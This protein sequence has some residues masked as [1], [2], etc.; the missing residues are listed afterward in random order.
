MKK[1][2]LPFIVSLAMAASMLPASFVMAE[3]TEEPAVEPVIVYTA[4]DGDTYNIYESTIM[5]FMDEN[6][7]SSLPDVFM[8]SGIPDEDLADCYYRFEA[9]DGYG[10]SLRASMYNDMAFFHDGNG[11]RD[12]LVGDSAAQFTGGWYKVSGL[13][14]ITGVNHEY[15]A[16][17]HECSHV[18]NISRRDTEPCGAAEAPAMIYTAPDGDTYN[19]YESTI[20]MFMDENENSSLPDVFMESGI[21]DEDLA[22]CYYRFEASDGYGTSLRAS[23]YNDMAF[24]HDGNGWRDTLVGDSAAQFTGGWYKVSGLVN[25]TGV[26]HEYSAETHECSHVVNISRR[27]TEPCGAAEPGDLIYKAPDG[28]VYNLYASDIEALM[29]YYEA[30]VDAD[31]ALLLDVLDDAGVAPED[32]ADCAYSFVAADGYFAVLPAENANI[33]GLMYQ[34]GTWRD[35]YVDGSASG[36]QRVKGVYE[37]DGFNHSYD[38]EKHICTTQI[39]V[40][41]DHATGQPVGQD[42]GAVDPD[43]TDLLIISQPENTNAAVGAKASYKETAINADTY[44]WYYSKDGSKWYKSTAAGNETPSLSITVKSNNIN[45]IYR[46]MITGTDGSV[47]YTD[48]VYNE[49]TEAPLVVGGISCTDIDDN[50]QATFTV[51][52]ENAENY[53]WYY[54]K[55]GSKWYKSTAD[56]IMADDGSSSSATITVK[57]SNMYNLYRCLVTGVDGTTAYSDALGISGVPVI[58]AFIA[59]AEVPLGGNAVFAVETENADTCQ[60][61]YS[62][63]GEKKWYQSNAAGSQEDTLTI[64]VKASN[65]GMMYRCKVTASCGLSVTSEEGTIVIQ[66][67]LI[68]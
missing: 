51:T 41:K 49:I 68:S 4:P 66:D 17:T 39:T 60:W 2:I 20:M 16:E 37:I 26:N 42:C 58:T 52:A 30:P 9:S 12:T 45:N 56:A 35:T 11:W 29:T 10:T 43:F 55:D 13:V 8:E 34:K 61:Y 25:I 36:F 50:M 65:N 53:E 5:M 28:D 7:N 33:I 59:N 38:S 57:A 18:V 22:D 62:K 48:N 1:R 44:Q 32:I 21:P 3:P 14:S 54:S 64:K 27:D 6:E 40:G 47:Q 15:A 19:I 23:M 46:C 63:D 67:V 24:F 31:C